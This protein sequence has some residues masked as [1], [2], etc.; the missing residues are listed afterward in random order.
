[1]A[2]W[3]EQA[4]SRLNFLT[5]SFQDKTLA[6]LEKFFFDLLRMPPYKATVVVCPSVYLLCRIAAFRLS[7]PRC[8]AGV[9]GGTVVSITRFGSLL[10]AVSWG[11][12]LVFWV[13]P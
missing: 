2:S 13:L 5:N 7:R 9:S 8:C 10:V 4:W 1:M 12:P 6:F 3:R 11:L